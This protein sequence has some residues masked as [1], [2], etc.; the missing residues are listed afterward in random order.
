MNSRPII[1]SLTS[2]AL[3]NTEAATDIAKAVEKRINKAIP[4]Q[5]LYAF[6]LLDSICKNVG[7]PYPSLF[8]AN[9]FKLFSQ[10]YSLVD[11]PTRVKLIKLFRTWKIP[12]AVTGLSLFDEDQIEL[13]DKFLIRATAANRPPEQ[14][15][16]IDLSNS[17][18]TKSSLLRE[19]DDLTN[20]VNSRILQMPD[21][22]K[23]R[24]RFQLLQKLRTI[25]SQPSSIPQQQLDFT[26]KQ[27]QSIREDELLRLNAFKQQQ[28]P[29]SKQMPQLSVN[30]LQGLLNLPSGNNNNF[31]SY[32]APFGKPQ[33]QPPNQL[34]NAN[35]QALFSMMSSILNQDQKRQQQ[36]PQFQV[37]NGE[38]NAK[39]SKSSSKDPSDN[40]NESSLGLTNL[41]FLKDI[42]RK[43]KAGVKVPP[44]KGNAGIIRVNEKDPVHVK[45]NETPEV[46]LTRFELNQNFINNH[47]PTEEEIA[48]IYTIKDNQCSN[49]SKRFFSTP[50]DA[51][52]KALHL[53]WHF[54]TNKKL[55]AMSKQIHNR[56]WFLSD[57]QW[58]QFQEDEIVGGND[59]YDIGVGLN[60]RINEK[61]V[62]TEKEMNK[63][64]VTIPDDAENEVI[65]GICR[66]KLVGV[67]DDDSGEWIWRNAIK[68][69][70]RVYHYSCWIETKGQ[71]DRDRSPE[72]R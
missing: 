1:E 40:S 49:C 17:K 64:V 45:K 27:L 65:C 46:I 36:Q 62:L 26:K 57:Q 41:E 13:I 70:G 7:V 61:P 12:N 51:K 8:G 33:Q 71:G 16:Q 4:S 55:K 54:R 31:P 35:A 22:S 34:N 38:F 5:K 21:D 72:R 24:E 15:R 43:S 58:E 3:E 28:Q 18:A 14:Q 59:N 67:F 19:I 42:L 10:A 52:K 69:R 53:D 66:D 30:Q 25:L 9:I 20:L 60:N 2:L 48:L 63:K 50:E 47:E 56:S 39:S 6:Y 29:A 32:Q 44:M 11:D 23:G 37:N 68:Q